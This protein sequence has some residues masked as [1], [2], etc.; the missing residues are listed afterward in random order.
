M[1]RNVAPFAQIF[2]LAAAGTVDGT[3]A[4][5]GGDPLPPQERAK[6]SITTIA[7]AARA[8]SQIVPVLRSARTSRL[9][10]TSE[11]VESGPLDVPFTKVPTL[12]AT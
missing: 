6:P 7:A 11:I 8:K 5:D 4:R 10:R 9:L 2:G 1:K 12:N 3:E